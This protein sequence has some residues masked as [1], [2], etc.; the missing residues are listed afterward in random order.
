MAVVFDSA[1]YARPDR[2][3]AAGMVFREQSAP[4]TVTF[5]SSRPSVV[6]EAWAFGDASAFR[7]T[8]TGNRLTRSATDIRRGPD[9]RVAIATQERGIARL[10]QYGVRR[11]VHPGELMVVDLDAP[12]DYG[13]TGFGAA[14]TI[15]V[16]FDTLRLSRAQVRGAALRSQ[17]SPLCDLIRR[18]L[19]NLALDRDSEVGA[20]GAH[21]LGLSTVA[22]AAAFLCSTGGEDGA[23]V[24]RD[25]PDALVLTV[26]AF[27]RTHL[28]DPELTAELIAE[29]HGLSKHELAQ[30]TSAQGIDLEQWI[31]ALRLH[32]VRAE[33]RAG[34]A[35]EPD[36][37]LARRWG[38]TDHR[39]L[40]GAFRRAYGL[41]VRHWWRIRG[42]L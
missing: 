13:W 18:H 41:G 24:V 37:G 36:G 11:L 23:D 4:A 17:S 15:H 29:Q 3:E 33:L 16:P 27:V 30:R 42:E 38:F 19:M 14:R 5:F 9:G 35:P 7:A 2:A 10:E 22:L 40:D 8:M 28:T 20:S 12:Y 39:H 34:R 21:A 1:A 32:G 25:S 31:L 26:L 6:M